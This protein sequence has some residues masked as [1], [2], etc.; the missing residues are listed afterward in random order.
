MRPMYIF[1]AAFASR[2]LID[3]SSAAIPAI[4]FKDSIKNFFLRIQSKTR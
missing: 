4:P 2:G 1:I 3:Y